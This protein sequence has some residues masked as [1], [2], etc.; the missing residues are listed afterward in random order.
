MAGTNLNKQFRYIHERLITYT[1]E[2]NNHNI[3]SLHMDSTRSLRD[4]T[5]NM[6]SGPQIIELSHLKFAGF[7]PIPEGFVQEDVK[8]FQARNA[9]IKLT[10]VPVYRTRRSDQY[11]YLPNIPCL[12]LTA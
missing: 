4:Q 5:S 2:E 1:V 3:L 7:Q 8:Y 12:R 11:H 9:D 6:V 10:S